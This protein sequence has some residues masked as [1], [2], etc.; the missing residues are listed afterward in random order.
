MRRGRPRLPEG[1]RKE[2]FPLRIPGDDVRE[3]QRIAGLRQQP[4]RQWMVE[5]L[6]M[7][8]AEQATHFP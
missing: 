6:R 1:Q 8:A 2:L 3:F 7:V 5:A 4:L